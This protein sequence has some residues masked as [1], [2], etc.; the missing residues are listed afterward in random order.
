[1][2]KTGTKMLKKIYD[3][4]GESDTNAIAKELKLNNQDINNIGLALKSRGLVRKRVEV[5]PCPNCPGLV[6]KKSFWSLREQKR[7]KVIGMI[8]EAYG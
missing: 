5:K 7:E 3:D 1:M 4:S 2:V 6:R 8:M